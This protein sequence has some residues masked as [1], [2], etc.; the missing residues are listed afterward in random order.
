MSYGNGISALYRFAAV[1]FDTAFEVFIRGPNGAEG[2]LISVTSVVTVQTTGS[3]T[4][5]EVG[6]QSDADAYATQT[7]AAAAVETSVAAFTRGAD[8]RI[9]ADTLVT[10]AGDGGNTAG[11]GDVCVLIEWYGGDAS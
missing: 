1:T 4:T 5:I 7:V 2:R 10:I 3:D 9:P 11:D 6:N 8:N